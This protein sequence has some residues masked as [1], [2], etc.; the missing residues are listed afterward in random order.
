[1]LKKEQRKLSEKNLLKKRKRNREKNLNHR[2]STN[3]LSNNWAQIV[4]GRERDRERE[5]SSPASELQQNSDASSKE[6]C[7]LRILTVL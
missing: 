3:R 7:I 5:R 2:V 6:T 1:M 4:M